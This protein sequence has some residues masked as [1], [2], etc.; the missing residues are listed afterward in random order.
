MKKLLSLILAISLQGWMTGCGATDEGIE[1]P[2]EEQDL[3]SSFDKT[4]TGYYSDQATEIQGLYAG[5][6]DLDLSDMGETERAALLSDLRAGGWKL[7]NLVGDHIKYGKN[8]L[9]TEKLH[10]NLSAQDIQYHDVTVEGTSARVVYTL[11]IE[12]IVS[13]EELREAGIDLDSLTNREF[14]VV[15]PADPRN[16]FN[17]VGEV[18]AEGFDAGS[19]ADYN[20]FY[21]FKPDKE[22]CTLPLCNATFTLQSLLPQKTTYPEYDRLT[23]DGKVTVAVFFGAAGH[24][25][26]VSYYDEGMR[27]HREFVSALKSRGFSKKE[28]LDPKGERYKR[29]RS[30]LEEI[31]D[32][33]SPTDL[34]ALQHDT[35]GIFTQALL[36]HEIVIY[37]GHSFYGSLSVLGDKDAYPA[38]TYQILFMNSCWSYEYYT[39]QV[40]EH[41]ASSDDHEGWAL[42][43]VVNNTEA[44]WFLN[45]GDETRILLTNLLA[46]CE[47][48]GREGT[49]HYTWDAIVEAMNK[50]AMDRFRSWNLKSHEIYGVSGVRSNC[51]DPDNPDSCKGQGNQGEGE[52]VTV[53]N[54]EVIAIPDNQPD[55]ISSG[56][57]VP[58]DIAFTS[59]AVEVDIEHTWVGDLDISLEHNGKVINLQ[60]RQGGSQKNLNTT[61]HPI[62]FDGLGSSGDWILRISDNA[63]RDTGSLKR[64]A[65]TLTYDKEAEDPLT[66]QSTDGVDIPDNDENGVASNI[67]VSEDRTIASL[68]V[69]VDIAHTYVGDLVIELEHVGTLITLQDQEGGSAEN[70][71]AE[72]RPQDFNASS[73]Q[74]TWTLV[75]SDRAQVDTG[76]LNAWSLTFGN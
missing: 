55:G 64:W 3:V 62:G 31:V 54:T 53:E 75:V 56:I 28:D 8:Q 22:G 25:E 26:E 76:R 67:D 40:F 42:A 13:R 32:V 5:S 14:P 36:T 15:L 39:K 4:D 41:K 73:T 44:G 7:R 52:V 60:S 68:L 21:Y 48:G 34:H 72:F 57:N 20:Y 35:D 49:R 17:R 63:N 37:D 65:V 23:V 58:N 16:V 9:N 2:P 70:L 69:T 38:D 1:I 19:L 71:Q 10:V 45:M 27:E 29:T 46:G 61:F 11:G 24:E 51:Y 50:H 12:S 33:V 66:Y 74:G 59:I 30:G 43:D 47:S 6:M 18:C